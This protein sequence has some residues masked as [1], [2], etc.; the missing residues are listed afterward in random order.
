MVSGDAPCMGT[1][2]CALSVRNGGVLRFHL[3]SQPQ[4]QFRHPT[5]E[6]PKLSHDWQIHAESSTFQLF[7]L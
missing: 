4:P 5:A 3:A 6:I 2:L 7:A 1:P